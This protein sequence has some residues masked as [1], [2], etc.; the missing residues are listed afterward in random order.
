[1]KRL[2]WLLIPE[3]GHDLIYR[4]TGWRIVEIRAM[5]KLDFS[6]PAMYVW[7]RKYPL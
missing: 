3:W 4:L 5:H 7:S 6:I 2:L 1:M